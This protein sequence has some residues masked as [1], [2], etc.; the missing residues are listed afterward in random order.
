MALFSILS[1]LKWLVA[2]QVIDDEGQ[3]ITFYSWMMK[4]IAIFASIRLHYTTDTL[5]LGKYEWCWRR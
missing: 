3:K 4:K 1:A 5:C 2:L